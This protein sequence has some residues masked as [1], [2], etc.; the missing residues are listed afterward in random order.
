MYPD[1]SHGEERMGGSIVTKYMA[2]RNC[3]GERDGMN[4]DGACMLE[5]WCLG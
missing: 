5:V 4:E 1:N 3:Y 2:I